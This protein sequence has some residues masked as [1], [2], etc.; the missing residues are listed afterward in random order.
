MDFSE[1]YIN[2]SEKAKELQ[3]AHSVYE[4]GDFYF[5]GLDSVTSEPRFSVTP[6]SD[7]GKDRTLANM[8]TWLPRQDQLLQMAGDYIEQCNLIH[9][10]LMRE[11]LLPNPAISSM[12]QLCLTIIMK[13]KY[14]KR[15]NGI[16]W[17]KPKLTA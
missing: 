1:N 5:E 14:S 4:A 9:R 8:K 3:I 17:V 6:D 2:M 13:E 11:L 7:H 16:D 15:W 12:E 10:N